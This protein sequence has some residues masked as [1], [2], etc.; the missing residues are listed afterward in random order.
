MRPFILSTT[1]SVVTRLKCQ[2]GRQRKNLKIRLD[3]WLSYDLIPWRFN[4]N[5]IKLSYIFTKFGDPAPHFYYAKEFLFFSPSIKATFLLGYLSMD[6][7]LG[8]EVYI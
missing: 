5:V 7:C 6:E 2:K 4:V 3:R 1:K 8:G